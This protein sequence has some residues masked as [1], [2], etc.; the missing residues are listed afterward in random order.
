MIGH[1]DVTARNPYCRGVDGL[2][3]VPELVLEFISRR[4][5]IGVY[6]GG[7]GFWCLWLA[8][9][10]LGLGSTKGFGWLAPDAVG[11]AAVSTGRAWLVIASGLLAVGTGLWIAS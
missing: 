7:V 1:P 8:Y 3:N 2:R 11:A 5:Y 4:D 6:L 9:R 10:G